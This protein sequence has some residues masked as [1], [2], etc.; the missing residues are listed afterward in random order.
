MGLGSEGSPAVTF[1]S[2]LGSDMASWLKNMFSLDMSS[3]WSS[4][5]PS[6]DFRFRE[7]EEPEVFCGVYCIPTSS[8]VG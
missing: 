2:C 7:E 3:N 8:V 1:I 5:I 4:I 6:P